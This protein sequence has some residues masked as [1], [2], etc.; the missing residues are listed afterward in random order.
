MGRILEKTIKNRKEYERMT[1]TPF[2][3]QAT[4]WD[5]VPVTFVNALKYLFN[6]EDIPP[7]AIQRIW[8]SSLDSI[9]KHGELGIGGT[10]VHGV[11]AIMYFLKEYFKSYKDGEFQLKCEYLHYCNKTNENVHLRGRSK[12][13]SCINRGGVAL[14]TVFT[15]GLHYV[16]GL[17]ADPNDSNRFLLFDPCYEKDRKDSEHIKFLDPNPNNKGANVSVSLE[18]LDSHKRL[19]YSMGDIKNRECCLIERI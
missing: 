12:I 15:D 5:C 4:E 10:D 14:I 13:K 6:R 19:M 1:K 16:L 2:S 18:R 17:G 7:I 8:Q 11:Q 9:S 3:Y